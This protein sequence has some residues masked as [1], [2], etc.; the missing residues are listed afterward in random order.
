[1]QLGKALDYGL[2]FHPPPTEVLKLQVHTKQKLGYFNAHSHTSLAC[3]LINYKCPIPKHE[4]N[5]EPQIVGS[6]K[7]VVATLSCAKLGT[8]EPQLVSIKLAQAVDV[9][10]GRHLSCRLETKLVATINVI[11]LPSSVP[12]AVPVK[13]N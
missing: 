3:F 4:L 10:I 1:M 12:V 7:K 9:P 2:S 6:S 13:F 8:A 5:N 11:I